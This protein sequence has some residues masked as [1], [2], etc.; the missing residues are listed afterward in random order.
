MLQGYSKQEK[1]YIYKNEAIDKLRI[2]MQT[3]LD[4][5]FPSYYAKNIRGHMDIKH[6]R[7]VVNRW[8]DEYARKARILKICGKS[9]NNK[10]PQVGLFELIL[11]I[12]SMFK[13]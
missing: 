7:Y 5:N 10:T 11:Y 13:Q 12:C 9:A 2:E 1:P 3:I 4:R 8:C 6:P